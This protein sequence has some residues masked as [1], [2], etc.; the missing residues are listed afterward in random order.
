MVDSLAAFF[1]ELFIKNKLVDVVPAKVVPTWHNGRSGDD[2]IEKII[3]QMYVV[4]DI[5]M[6]SMRYMT[7]LEYPYLTDHSLV[8]LQLGVG[9]PAVAHPFKLN[10]SWL[11][12]ESFSIMVWEV[13]NESHFQQFDGSQRRI[14]KK[15]TLLKNRVK[16]WSKEKRLQDHLELGNI[17]EDLN[18]IYI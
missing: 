6:S 13:W 2:G 18:N 11:R 12:E 7:C 16:L 17:E 3:Y 1:K 8:F 14:V 4:E 15:L 9:I 10:P 5:I